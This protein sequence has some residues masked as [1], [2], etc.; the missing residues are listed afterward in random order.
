[1]IVY[2]SPKNAL[3]AI[4]KKISNSNSHVANYGLIVSTKTIL[5]LNKHKVFIF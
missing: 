2:C 3:A 1:M 4:Q 5:N